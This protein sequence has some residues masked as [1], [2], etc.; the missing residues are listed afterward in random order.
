MNVLPSLTLSKPSPITARAESPS[1]SLSQG[2]SRWC[3][4]ILPR[5]G[6]IP[7]SAW[8]DL[9]ADLEGKICCCKHSD[10]GRER[11]IEEGFCV[12]KGKISTRRFEVFQSNSHFPQSV[13]LEIR[14]CFTTTFTDCAVPT[15]W[16][17]P[18]QTETPCCAPDTSPLFLRCSWPTRRPPALREPKPERSTLLESWGQPQQP[19]EW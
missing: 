18:G 7:F 8:A 19:C 4:H 15:L 6:S 13:H 1:P 17:T 9:G 5:A 3:W 14:R 2:K 11:R 10:E 12:F 16:K